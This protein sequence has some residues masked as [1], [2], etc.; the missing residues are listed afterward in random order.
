MAERP[1]VRRWTLSTFLLPPG[2]ARALAVMTLIDAVGTGV[3][4]SGNVIYFKHFVGL[5]AAQVSLGASAAGVAGLVAMGTM[6]R[7]AD[8]YGHRRVFI[9]LSVVQV[10]GYGG[11]VVVGSFP[12]YLALICFLGFVD[13]G[14]SPAREALVSSATTPATRVRSRAVLR[15][16]FNVGFAAGSG[17]STL[18]LTVD[19]TVARYGLVL[20][21]SGSF[22]V[23]GVLALRLPAARPTA[24]RPAVKR[25]RALANVPFLVATAIAG[26]LTLHM[27][28]LL[29]VLPLWV[30]TRTAAP[31]GIVGILLIVNTAMIVLLQVRATRGL[32][33]LADGSRAARRAAVVLAAGCVLLGLSAGNHMWISTAALAAGTVVITAGEMLQSGSRWAI[34]V[35]LAPEHA[36]A[37]YLGAFNM[38]IA[39]QSVVGPF[40][41][42][43]LVL[44]LG[45]A[46]WAVL[47]AV[48]I[49]AGLATGPSADWAHR[50]MVRATAAERPARDAV[51]AA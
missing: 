51:L 5:S 2:A 16:L 24:P 39:G 26:V 42:T 44:G 28:V 15:S 43:S 23:G 1:A 27:S 25:L 18:L 36:Q 41:C 8:R 13:F 19:G 37:E 14:K 7:V 38:S 29:V 10:I 35:G 3:F 34:G 6:G 21:N 33:T 48:F 12:S 49:A 11:Y 17:L 50:R 45:P 30:L 47:G 31:A 22:L 40:L 46:G 4:L 32:E 20:I 9:L